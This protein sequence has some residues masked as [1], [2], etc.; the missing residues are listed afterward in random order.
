MARVDVDVPASHAIPTIRHPND[1]GGLVSMGLGIF[2]HMTS[3]CGLF[4][5]QVIGPSR[6]FELCGPGDGDFEPDAV[7]LGLQATIIRAG[8]D[9]HGVAFADVEA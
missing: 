6:L 8:R 4:G 3:G 9:E 5:L 2:V 1:I 7:G